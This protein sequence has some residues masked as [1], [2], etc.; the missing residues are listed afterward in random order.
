MI[1][2]C[3]PES[4]CMTK[5]EANGVALRFYHASRAIPIRAKE[6]ESV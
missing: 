1:L 4:A 2:V 5:T 3:V 6:K